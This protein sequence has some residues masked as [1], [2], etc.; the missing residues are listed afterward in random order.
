MEGDFPPNNLAARLLISFYISSSSDYYYYCYH[1]EFT[2]CEISTPT[3][4]FI[5]VWMTASLLRSP[6]LF[7][8]FWPVLTIKVKLATVV[9]GDQNG[10]FSIATTPRCRGGHYSFPYKL[11]ILVEGDQKAPFSIA[12]TLRCRGWRHSFPW[13]APLYPWYVPYIAECYAR[14]YQVPF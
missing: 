12:T 10:S 6:G 2:A 4:S 9:E 14:R 8:V 11:A 1:F 7:S 13:I 3:W 5:G